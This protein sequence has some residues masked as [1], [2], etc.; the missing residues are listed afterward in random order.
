MKNMAHILFPADRGRLRFRFRLTLALFIVALMLSGL[1]A[2]PLLW[3]LNLMADWLNIG[4][5]AAPE[6][7]SG[8]AYWVAYVRQGLR[9]SYAAYPFL[10]Y[11]TDWLAF[12]H[13]VLA[14]FFIGPLL[15]PTENNWILLSGMSACVLV[16]PLALLC[17]VVRGIPLPWRLVDC[18]FGVVGFLP[19]LYCFL[20]ARR[21]KI[22][23]RSRA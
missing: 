13:I 4:P 2:F 15:K 19:L 10:A 20:L 7:L 1:T 18:A 3:E 22:I 17:G 14:V 16:I 5:H 6:S 12:A 8:L 9:E 21:M 23:D 11:G